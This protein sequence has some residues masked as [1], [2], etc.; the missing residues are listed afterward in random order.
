MERAP[1]A[2]S[3]VRTERVWYGW[4]TLLSDL[5]GV[6]LIALI[7]AEE[8]E[9]LAVAGFVVFGLGSPIVHFAH[10]N[11]PAGVISFGIRATSIGLLFLGGVLLSE[12]LFDDGDGGNFD[13]TTQVIGTV[14]VIASLPG[15]LTA[16]I[17]DAS[18]LAFEQR[19]PEPQRSSLTPWIDPRRGS[20]GVR[21]S[22]S[23]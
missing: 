16:V 22:L 18:L 1:A 15:A 12:T 3:E 20:Y 14:A 17:V 5:T 23:L 8:E 11:T 2:E 7:A 21:F 9:A 19:R 13:D 4:Q 6:G 10:G